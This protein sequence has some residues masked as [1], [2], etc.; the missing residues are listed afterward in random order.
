MTQQ[1]PAPEDPRGGETIRSAL[2]DIALIKRIID[3]AEI[4]L[5]RLGW[6]FLVYGSAM[7]A[8]RV[9][10][11][12]LAFSAA[13]S[14]GLRS[15]ADLSMILTAC[16]Y[17]VSIAL[18]VLFARKRV[19]IAKTENVYTMRLFD[20]WGVM[21]FAPVVLRCA[22]L[23]VGRI[24][25]SLD[26]APGNT[27]LSCMEYGA[28]CICVFFTGHSIGS[29]T[30][31]ITAAVLLF[32]FPVLLL[33]PFPSSVAAN[34]DADATAAQVFAWFN[35]KTAMISLLL[36]LVYLGMGLFSMKKQRGSA[37]GDE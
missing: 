32:L 17:A 8:F 9:S 28:L 6:L 5:R 3:R 7:L 20:L 13:R 30:L 36:P 14:A 16:S 24:A 10:E 21:L 35:A 19:R 23:L 11:N 26:T 12:V 31:R 4:N 34:I 1:I 25:P 27:L 22:L 37:Y 29:R 33:I 15:A 2:E 18:F